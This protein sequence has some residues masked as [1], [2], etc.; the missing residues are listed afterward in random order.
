[1]CPDALFQN[2]NGTVREAV[3]SDPNAIGYVSIGLVNDKVKPLLWNGVSATNENVNNQSYPLARPIY[4][5][6]RGEPA[7]PVKQFID[8]VL[9]PEGQGILAAE[10]LIRVK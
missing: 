10:G 3:A 5:L 7:A 6:T 2:S 4:F 9:S 1:L 8:F